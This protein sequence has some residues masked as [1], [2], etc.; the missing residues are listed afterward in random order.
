MCG[1]ATLVVIG[2]AGH[3]E[4]E[5]TLGRVN[6]P[7]HLVNTEDED[8]ALDMPPD[9]PLA[10]MTQTA[11]SMDD[12]HEVITTLKARFPQLVGPDVSGSCHA[13]QNRQV[14]VRALASRVDRVLVAGARNRSNA[15]GLR[16]VGERAGVPAH[17]VQDATEISPDWLEGAAR[18]GVTFCASAPE[19]LVQQL[20]DAL[21]TRHNG[22]LLPVL[23][24]PGA[25][26]DVLFRLPAEL[27]EP[28]A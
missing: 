23:Q 16:E 13:N 14:A 9:V 11:F 24:L 7:G 22:P 27:V 19:L 8:M 15:N 3:D 6:A 5:G 4:V 12:T 18:I 21:R 10:Y 1:W 26:E 25:Q 28:V 20:I 17:L 2:H